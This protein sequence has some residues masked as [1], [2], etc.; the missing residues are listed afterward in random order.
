MRCW[1]DFSFTPKPTNRHPDG[2]PTSEIGNFKQAMRPLRQLY[3]DTLACEFGPL[4]LK[5][6]QQKMI[7]L[8][9]CRPHIN[10]QIGRVKLMFKWA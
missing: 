7:A 10:K 6:L 4:K 9:W 2:S 1:H 5:A 3:G 8:D